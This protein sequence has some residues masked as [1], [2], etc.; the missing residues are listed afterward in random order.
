GEV[1]LNNFTLIAKL[2][3]VMLGDTLQARPQFKFINQEVI[4][5]EETIN[6]AGLRIAFTSITPPDPEKKTPALY[7]FSIGERPIVRDYVVLKAQVMPWINL[8]W[9]GTIVMIIG[10]VMSIYRRVKEYMKADKQ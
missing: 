10:F 4:S 2:K 1:D 8:V 3:L 7:H 9:A 6:E 5:P